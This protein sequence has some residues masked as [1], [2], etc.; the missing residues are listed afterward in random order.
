MMA[1]KLHI[2]LLYATQTPQTT[3]SIALDTAYLEGL[4]PGTKAATGIYLMDNRFGIGSSNEGTQSIHT[5]CYTGDKISW[6][7][8]PVDAARGDT[9]IITGF[10]I[11]AGN[12]FGGSIGNP[13]PTDNPACWIG[14]AVVSAS[15]SVYQINF[16]IV[17]DA[18][19]DFTASCVVS[20][21]TFTSG[22]NP[23]LT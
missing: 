20:I 4:K 6:L 17:D 16:L 2:S 13:Q 19:N 21:A 11:L 23:K 22:N 12:I 14:R 7:A 5:V 9:V 18:K 15:T 3:I 10:I 1:D 8:L